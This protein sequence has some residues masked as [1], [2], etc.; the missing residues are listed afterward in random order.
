[1]PT[2]PACVAEAGPVVALVPAAGASVRMGG[3]DKL[4]EDVGG[5]PALGRAVA[6]ASAAASRVLVTLPA[7][8]AGAAR[9]AALRGSG[10]TLIDIAGPAEG[11]AAS[12]RAGA[13]AAR[14]AAALLIHLPDM[15]D[16]DGDDLCRV[17][18]AWQAAPDRP[19]RATSDRGTPGHPVVLPAALFA[20]VAGLRGD[21]G[22]RAL[23]A[24]LPVTEVALPGDRATL[25]LDTPADWALWRA[26]RG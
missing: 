17:V 6:V 2:A 8:A 7:G 20:A 11:M 10:A 1:M 19:A 26:R 16:L 15:P 24:G 22:A 13:A 18:V 5:Q 23:L 3:R 14:G 12:L 25:D 21:V 9:R 4:L